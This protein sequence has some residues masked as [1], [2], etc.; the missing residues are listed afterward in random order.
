MASPP[1]SI[2]SSPRSS[3]L[4]RGMLRCRFATIPI[5][6]NGLLGQALVFLY[7]GRT[8]EAFDYFSKSLNVDP[9][10][11][12]TLIYKAQGLRNMSKLKETEQVYNQIIA[13]RPNYWPAYNELGWVLFWEAKY[14]QAAEAFDDAANAAPDVALPL[15]NLA[16]YVS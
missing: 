4:R 1:S 9:G 12:E 11:P 6:L 7:S 16:T 15:A 3:S 10:N 14:K 8:K 5:Q 2:A 13:E